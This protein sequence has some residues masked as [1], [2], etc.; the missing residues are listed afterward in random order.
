MILGLELILF[1][2]SYKENLM[3]KLIV[4]SLILLAFSSVKLLSQDL[5]ASD[6]AYF[7]PDFRTKPISVINHNKDVYLF[8]PR[9]GDGATSFLKYNKEFDLIQKKNLPRENY[10]FPQIRGYGLDSTNTINLYFS[11][12][13]S[14]KF[15]V[16]SI[17]KNGENKETKFELAI[18]E[19]EKVI[20]AFSYNNIFSLLTYS[21]GTS[22]IHRYR[23]DGTTYQKTNYD[24]YKQGFCEKLNGICDLRAIFKKNGVQFI[25]DKVPATITQAI[26]KVKIYPTEDYIHITSDHRV[27]S[28]AL[29]SLSLNSNEFKVQQFGNDYNDFKEY[30]KI[31]SNSFLHN[32]YLFQI[33]AAKHKGKIFIKNTSDNNIVNS[34]E[35]NSEDNISFNNSEIY[36]DKGSFSLESEVIRDTKK[37]LNLLLKGALGL[38]VEEKNNSFLMVFGG[39]GTI[40]TSA[41]PNMMFPIANLGAF[42]LYMGSF[43]SVSRSRAVYTRSLLKKEGFTQANGFAG[44]N[45][46]ELIHVYKTED[47]RL[48]KVIREQIFQ[49]D[50]FYVYGYY[51]IRKGTYNLMKF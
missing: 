23:F 29:I 47:A 39:V 21:K 7:N 41:G 13:N 30:A 49:Y 17:A 38:T 28:T 36:E 18:K 14:E 44:I 8:F 1:G 20:D 34:Y 51:D 15:L 48:K 11:S 19:G 22:I 3:K 16:I 35:F 5:I 4:I 50:D 9:N 31:K 25:S 12:K 43:Y 24:L 10:G 37:F 33:I 26:N 45:I 42:N 2:N 32:G 40:T 6:S 27:G 46:F